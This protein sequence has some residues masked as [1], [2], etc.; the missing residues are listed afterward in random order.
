MNFE[1]V[2]GDVIEWSYKDSN[3]VVVKTEELWSTPM[4]KWVPIGSKLIHVL[5][6]IDGHHVNWLNERGLFTA[7]VNDASSMR[8]LT[9]WCQVV[10]HKKISP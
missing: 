9:G 1:M 10:P 6:A 8:T 5:V 3:K 7:C 2:P 4:R